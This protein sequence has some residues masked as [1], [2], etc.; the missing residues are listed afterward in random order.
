MRECEISVSRITGDVVC[1][2]CGDDCDC[3]VCAAGQPEQARTDAISV[4]IERNGAETDRRGARPRTNGGL[5]VDPNANLREQRELARSILEIDNIR[6]DSP[7]EARLAELALALDEW[8]RTGGFD[9]YANAEDTFTLHVE[10]DNVHPR[11][12]AERTA[13]LLA[14]VSNRLRAGQT[15]GPIVDAGDIVGRYHMAHPSS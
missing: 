15:D 6:E 10:L 12:R 4:S 1:T 11:G 9:P 2:R 3:L 5:T 7:D 13:E 14:D 8:R